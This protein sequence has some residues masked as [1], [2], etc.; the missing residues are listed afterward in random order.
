MMLPYIVI[1]KMKVDT[2][3]SAAIEPTVILPVP[4]LQY[5]YTDCRKSIDR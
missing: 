4:E 2:M 3:I 5:D 1:I